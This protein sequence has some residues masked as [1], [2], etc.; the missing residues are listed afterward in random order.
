M[1]VNPDSHFWVRSIS[2]RLNTRYWETVILLNQPTL[3]FLNPNRDKEFLSHGFICSLSEERRKKEEKRM[4]GQPHSN[5]WY[6]SIS[7]STLSSVT[8]LHNVSFRFSWPL[9]IETPAARSPVKNILWFQVEYLEEIK[10]SVSKSIL[11]LSKLNGSF[12]LYF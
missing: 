7:A 12:F 9:F 8:R 5:N 3:F 4:F 2:A 11:L 6:N 10:D 1:Y